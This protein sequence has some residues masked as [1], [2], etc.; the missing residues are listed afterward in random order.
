M[1]EPSSPQEARRSDL[2]LAFDLRALFPGVLNGG[3][4]MVHTHEIA[5]VSELFSEEMLML[6]LGTRRKGRT[7]TCQIEF[8]KEPS[9]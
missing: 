5:E 3:G 8:Q 2:A 6:I 9:L 7:R 1:Q 4:S